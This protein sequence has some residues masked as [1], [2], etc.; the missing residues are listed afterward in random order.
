[1]RGGHHQKRKAL[2][3]KEAEGDGRDSVPGDTPS[4]LEGK[5]ISK[6]TW[7][8]VHATDV[9]ELV[10]AAVLDGGRCHPRV[11]RLPS[12]GGFGTTPQHIHT[13]LMG[14]Y[15]KGIGTPKADFVKCPVVEPTEPNEIVFRDIAS[16]KFHKW[17][18]HLHE[19][20]HD[21]YTKIFG[22][23]KAEQFWKDAD[24]SEPK[25]AGVVVCLV[26]GLRGVCVSFMYVAP[27]LGEIQ[28]SS[29][30][31][32]F[33]SK[34]GRSCSCRSSCTVTVHSVGG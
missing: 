1:M 26:A 13:E 14:E 25:C 7:G 34:G 10:H 5:L 24:M 17:L 9:R 20:Y 19:H 2:L 4:A 6:W 30:T 23:D 18:T 31:Q 29:T 22:V 3:C 16:F 21:D 11:A 32:C 15:A 27:Y 33:E 12:M 28:S 8:K